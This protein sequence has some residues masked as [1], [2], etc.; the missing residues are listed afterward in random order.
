MTGAW[1]VYREGQRWRR[2][3]RRAWLV[4]RAGGHDGRAVRRAGARA[5]DRLARALRPAH[6]RPRPRHPRARARRAALPARLREDDPTRPI[7]DALL[8]Q[9]TIA[10]IGNLWK[11]EGC[12]DAGDRPV[13]RRRATSPTTRRCA[14]CASRARACSSPRATATRRATRRST[15]ASGGRARAAARRS[16]RAARATTTARHTGAPDASTEA[17]RPQ[18]RRPHRAGQHARVLRRGAG[19]RRRHGRVRRPARAP[20]R[21]GAPRARPRLRRPRRG[22]SRSRSR[23]AS[24]TSPRTPGRA[25]SSTS[26]SS[27]PATR[28]ASSTRCASTAW[29]SARSIST[30]EEESLRIVRAAGARTSA[31]AGRSPSCGATTWPTRSRAVPALR[32]RAVRAARCCPARAARAIRDGPRR[33]AHVALGARDPAPGA[34]DRARPAASSTCGRSTTRRG[35][36]SSTR[37]GVTGVITNDPRLFATA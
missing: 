19:R 9:R 7:G 31:S 8:D 5:A 25:S 37:I 32:R 23:R 33:R 22:A 10:G 3:P 21:L 20:R 18:G 26:T 2:S 29:P 1:G 6:R 16:A 12:F 28:R 11:C 17:H 13:A 4:L 36:P 14:S 27:H 15:A 35:S 30:M 34:G 24:P